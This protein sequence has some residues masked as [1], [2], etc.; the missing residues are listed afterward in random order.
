MGMEEKIEL[1]GFDLEHLGKERTSSFIH[2]R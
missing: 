1:A 2:V